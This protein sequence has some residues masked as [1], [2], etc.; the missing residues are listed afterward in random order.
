[1]QK[2]LR[3]KSWATIFETNDSYVGDAHLKLAIRNVHGYIRTARCAEKI[4]LFLQ[5]KKKIGCSVRLFF[6]LTWRA[7][8]DYTH[9][10][11]STHDHLKA[12]KSI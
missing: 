7:G 4:W 1:M 10:N 3:K 11:T 6:R 2:W 5:K 12:T 9:L 8:R